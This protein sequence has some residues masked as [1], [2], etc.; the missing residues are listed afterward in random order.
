MLY[1]SSIWVVASPVEVV[2]HNDHQMKRLMEEEREDK[3]HHLE[4]LVYKVE[5]TLSMQMMS[6]VVS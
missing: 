4:M 5:K 6:Y 1:S 3:W 2:I